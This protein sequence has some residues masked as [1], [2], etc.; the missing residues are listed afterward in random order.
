LDLRKQIGEEVVKAKQAEIDAKEKI[1]TTR[2]KAYA[3]MGAEADK[4]DGILDKTTL[5]EY[6]EL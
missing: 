2:E 5:D 3:D 6:E 4:Y 1:A